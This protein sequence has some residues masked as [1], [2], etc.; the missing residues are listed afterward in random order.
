MPDDIPTQNAGDVTPASIAEQYER[1]DAFISYSHAADGSLAP[2]LQHGLQTLAKPLYQRKAL[3]V[4]RDQTNLAATPG[5]WST[6]EE[7]LA[8]SRFFVL[9]ASPAA[10]ESP[11][12]QQE[13]DWWH[14][15]RAPSYRCH[16]W[17]DCVGPRR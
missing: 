5:L 4:F 17:H 6:I 10:A 3:W 1:Y 11:W 8:A 14:R 9:L 16:A 7:A 2:A 13:L 15:H 12:V